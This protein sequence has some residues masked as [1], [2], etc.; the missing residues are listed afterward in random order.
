MEGGA[1]RFA[2]RRGAGGGFARMILPQ[3][4]SPGANLGKIMGA[5]S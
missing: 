4:F 3:P 5:K 2:P 1:S